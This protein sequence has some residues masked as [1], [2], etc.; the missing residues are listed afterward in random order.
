MYMYVDSMYII[1]IQYMNPF[2]KRQDH[3]SGNGNTQDV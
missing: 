1:N 3:D 2:R